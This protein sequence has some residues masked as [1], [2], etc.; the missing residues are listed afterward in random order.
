M[1]YL[2]FSFC[3]GLGL[4]VRTSFAIWLRASKAECSF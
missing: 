3:W 1:A 4:A 2:G